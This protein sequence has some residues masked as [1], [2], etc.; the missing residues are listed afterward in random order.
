MIGLTLLWSDPVPIKMCRRRERQSAYE[1]MIMTYLSTFV[2]VC[3]LLSPGIILIAGGRSP[4]RAS[5][6]E[7]T[8]LS[9]LIL[10]WLYPDRWGA[11]LICGVLVCL[12]GFLFV[13]GADF[14]AEITFWRVPVTQTPG[15]LWRG[16]GYFLA[17]GAAVMALA[18][19]IA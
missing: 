8:T 5:V 11:L 14:L 3:T 13:V 1:T 6:L 16:I 9:D 15:T 18:R 7:P 19:L 2:R 10:D 12:P 4:K 17:L